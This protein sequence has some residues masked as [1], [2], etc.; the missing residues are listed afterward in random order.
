MCIFGG[1]NRQVLISC[2]P[3]KFE[4]AI[5]FCIESGPPI[6]LSPMVNRKWNGINFFCPLDLASIP[7]RL[8]NKFVFTSAVIMVSWQFV[9]LRKKCDPCKKSCKKIEW[10]IHLWGKFSCT[11]HKGDA[12]M[13]INLETLNDIHYFLEQ[14]QLVYTYI[15]FKKK[16]HRWHTY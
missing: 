15:F 1:F 2:H 14:N 3:G 11:Q 10:I 5:V 16:R 9:P 4:M 8:A 6:K 13:L 12:C 7:W